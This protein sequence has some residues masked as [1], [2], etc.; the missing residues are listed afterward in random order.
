MASYGDLEEMRRKMSKV[1]E[2][3]RQKDLGF[4]SGYT[5][6]QISP[7]MNCGQVYSCA[8]YNPNNSKT[9]SDE[10][11]YYRSVGAENQ[12][13]LNEMR[14]LK[15]KSETLV[16]QNR[17]LIERVRQLES[18]NDIFKTKKD[19]KKNIEVKVHDSVNKVGNALTSIYQKFITWLNT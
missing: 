13:L 19:K 14:N 18:E 15:A 5:C 12:K 17:V 9:P 6:A 4:I 16:Y 1:L 11:F 7:T 10:E 2:E 3:Q 8:N